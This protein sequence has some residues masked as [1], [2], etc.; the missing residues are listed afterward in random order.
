MFSRQR[1]APVF[2][3][4]LLLPAPLR[5]ESGA[6][7]EWPV[8]GGD[9]GATHF[10]QL[11][12]IT[13]QNVGELQVAWT[14]RSGDYADGSGSTRAT[15]MQVTPLVVNGTLYYCT[16]F[17][18]VFA[19]DPETGT[20][21][22]SFD[23]VLKEKKG[24]GPYPLNCR[25]LSYWEDASAEPAA[26]CR[27]RIFYGTSDAELIALDAA[28]GKPC[29]DFGKDGRI[30]LRAAIGEVKSWTYYPTS[31]PLIMKDR[32]V[33][34][35][36]VADNLTVNSAPGVV[37]AY[38]ARRGELAWAWDPTPPGWVPGPEYQKGGTYQQG[39]PNSWSIMTGDEE[40]GLVYVPTGNPG[41]DLYGG[42]RNGLD[43]YGSSTVALSID[44]GQVVWHR[45]HVH[46]DVWDYDTPAPPTLF[47]IEGVGDGAPAL[48]Q[49]TKMGHLFL[50]D[51]ANGA[52][53][54]PIEERPVP[55]GGVPG[56]TL[57]PTQP[58]P[59]H[60]AP[61]HPSR[62]EPGDAHGFTPIDWFNC[63]GKIAKA[64]WDG[65]FTPPSLEGSIGYPHTSGGMNWGGV[66][67]D[68]VRGLLIVN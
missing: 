18:R 17:Q 32:V 4:L 39:S 10:S 34:N 19:L 56:E 51:R 67:I 60:P 33:I 54:Y 16:A 3:A 6:G 41:A 47:R 30:D 68:P 65:A 7:A 21:R 2:M 31:P 36:L 49:P 23:P 28:T 61:L 26:A 37:R 66:A 43:F 38:D 15:S 35:G 64:R 12:Q 14:H 63:R 42:Q 62:L 5:A 45:Q 9:A 40:L 44:T 27:T 48:V 22:W 55:Q 52:P 20:E 29:A 57:S 11:D 46:H 50:L 8:W 25:G 58:F 13:P 1:L 24:E 53:L 59:T